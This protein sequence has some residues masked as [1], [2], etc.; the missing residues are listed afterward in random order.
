M[1]SVAGLLLKT[2]VR[3]FYERNT[4]F[5]LFVFFLMF[6]VVESTQIVTYHLSLIYGLLHAPVFLAVVCL[7]WV[8]Y[9]L[10]CLAFVNDF[11]DSPENHFLSQL[12]LVASN[13]RLAWIALVFLFVDLPVLVY[14]SLIAAIGLNEGRY[15]TI[16]FIVVFHLV[17]LGGAS[18]FLLR[19]LNSLRPSSWHWPV[20]R[21]NRP[22]PFPLFYIAALFSRHKIVLFVTKAFS[23]FAI[24]GFLNIPLDHYEYRTA[25]MG[26]LFGVAGHAVLIFELRKL[27][28]HHLRFLRNLP[29]SVAQRFLILATVYGIVMFPEF[30]LLLVN[31]GNIFHA[32]GGY[33]FA[34]GLL[35]FS[36]G[37]LYIELNN[38]KHTQ[39]MLGLFLVSFMLVLFRVYGIETIAVWGMA[40]YYF[41]TRYYRFETSPDA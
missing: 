11:F 24:I 2:V 31:Q 17:L 7:A 37:R 27:E 4:G 15:A 39:F 10:K 25:L 33:L 34:V 20:V 6:G 19:K 35:L 21:L 23:F 41:N 40:F 5:F 36:H 32:V 28:E 14:V 3:K 9:M 16:A 30:I 12:N 18:M 1:V 29:L 22:L 13:K 8:L 26:L 38:D